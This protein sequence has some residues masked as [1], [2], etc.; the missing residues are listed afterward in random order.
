[1]RTIVAV[2]GRKHKRFY[3]HPQHQK[4]PHHSTANTSS[5][6]RPYTAR[7]SQLPSRQVPQDP[8]RR[9]SHHNHRI[10]RPGGRSLTHSERGVTITGHV[11]SPQNCQVSQPL[12]YQHC[13]LNPLMRGQP[14]PN[15]QRMPLPRTLRNEGD[16][17]CVS[18]HSCVP[19]ALVPQRPT[20]SNAVRA[21]ASTKAG[22]PPSSSHPKDPTCFSKLQKAPVKTVEPRRPRLAPTERPRAEA[23]FPAQRP[24][25]RLS[26]HGA[27]GNARRHSPPRPPSPRLPAAR[28]QGAAQPPS[29]GPGA[30]RP[31]VGATASPGGGSSGSRQSCGLRSTGRTPPK[32]RACGGPA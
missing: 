8:R 7:L 30:A 28:R 25:S 22:G 4:A 6:F 9:V 18:A 26:S 16:V 10:K 20:G 5:S 13:P 1:M 19:T 24:P 29:G 21:P 32:C 3:R 17:R 15:T 14:R 11:F 2:Q 23:V 27:G 31:Q 12:Y